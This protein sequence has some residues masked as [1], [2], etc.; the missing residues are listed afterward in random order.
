M[1]HSYLYLLLSLI[2]LLYRMN[3]FKQYDIIGFG[4]P[5][6]DYILEY[7]EAPALGEEIKQKLAYVMHKEDND[8]WERIFSFEKVQRNLGG[9][10]LNAIRIVNNIFKRNGSY[11]IGGVGNDNN[12][13][14]M[15]QVLTNEGV[16]FDL[17][18]S[19]GKKTSTVLVLIEKKDREL[20]GNL[21]S[22]SD[23]TVDFFKRNHEIFNHSHV[24]FSDAYL[25]HYIYDSYAYVYSTFAPNNNTLL[26]LGFADPKAV[27]DYYP[28]M[29]MIIPYCDI[30]FMN[31]KEFS[32]WVNMT[33]S[34]AN[35]EVEKALDEDFEQFVMQF[36]N[37]K[38]I[39]KHN[40]NKSF[41]VVITQGKKESIVYWKDYRE[42][43]SFIIKEPKW[44]YDERLVIDTTGVGDSFAGGFLTGLILGKKN[45]ECAIIG[46]YIAS[47]VLQKKG[48]QVPE[49]SIEE[50]EQALQLRRSNAN[51]NKDDL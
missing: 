23:L 29:S 47:K 39:D 45:N 17:Y 30:L 46:H 16:S 5:I 36:L 12:A 21:G 7:D 48:F 10:T 51:I 11:F 43:K 26:G 49:L 22:S 8:L 1:G 50:I 34:N 33:D 37:K 13:E 27:L 28:K 35:D 38:S 44:D 25:V 18:S 32:S 14:F 3:C 24:I 40:K 31:K 20:Y 15:K 6:I 4:M 41:I 2:K 42:D 9:S 19:F